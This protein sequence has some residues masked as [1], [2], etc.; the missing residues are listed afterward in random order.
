MVG[1]QKDPS[2]GAVVTRWLRWLVG[3]VVVIGA[4]WRADL[5]WTVSPLA[6]E[7]TDWRSRRVYNST[8]SAVDVLNES[9]WLT[10]RLPSGQTL[11]RVVTNA[12]VPSTFLPVSPSTEKWQYTLHYQLLSGAGA[13][14]LDRQYVHRTGLTTYV[15]PQ[16]GEKFTSRF[17]LDGDLFPT[18]GKV[19][20]INAGGLSAEPTHLRLRVATKANP[21][22]SLTARVFCRESATVRKLSTVWQ[23]LSEKQQLIL[24]RGNLY[25]PELLSKE[26]KH[27]LLR[28]RWSAIAPEGIAGKDYVRRDLYALKEFEEEE[29]REPVLPAGLLVTPGLHGIVTIPEGGGVLRLLF[30]PISGE[31]GQTPDHT[32]SLRW[33]GRG[34]VQRR[35]FTCPWSDNGSECR[36]LL[37]GGLL[38]VVT[39]QALVVRAFL[40]V[41][42]QETEITPEP[43]LTPMYLSQN[44]TPVEFAIMHV[45]QEPTPFRLTLRRPLAAI[46]GSTDSVNST[47]STLAPG[48]LYELLDARQQVLHAGQ[49]SIDTPASVY[50]RLL[51]TLEG[52]SLTDPVHYYF[53]LPPSVTR[54]RVRALQG[55]ILIT[56]ANRPAT[57]VREIQVPEDF[58]LFADSSLQR[59]WFPLQPVGIDQ[60]RVENRVLMVAVQPR[61]PQDNSE[62]MAGR[63]DWE[64]YQPPHGWR[65]RRLLLPMGPSAVRREQTLLVTFSEIPL[66]REHTVQFVANDGRR[67]IT[68][69]M[70]YIR[71]G[72]GL[73]PVLVR[74][75]IDGRVQ[76]EAFIQGLAGEISL[77][78][79][80]AGRHRIQVDAP[81]GGRV[82]LNHLA[83]DGGTAMALVKMAL[84]FDADGLGFDYEKRTRDEEEGLSVRLYTPYG[85]IQPTRVRVRIDGPPTK[86]IG[87]YTSWTF[88]ERRYRVRP[89]TGIRVPVLDTRDEAVTEGQLFS[90]PLGSDLPP[91]RYRIQLE[92]EDGPGGYLILSK[93]TP[94]VSEQRTVFL[95]RGVT[96]DVAPE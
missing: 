93:I 10:Y 87:P 29:T 80:S 64:D 53:S 79:L 23:R 8:V 26:E 50:D 71:H 51:T 19:M 18:D 58:Y 66:A 69:T 73:G 76:R 14:L 6:R 3:I 60:L 12:G 83:L 75:F 77:P 46:E 16:T 17:Y 96:I 2:G 1:V 72:R 9:Q 74:T 61:P 11:I 90:V 59:S 55:P 42:G 21:I 78:P 44:H 67:E 20:V 92:L 33:Y 28:Q 89:V 13:V 7:T 5:R 39:P 88:R 35:S 31:Q 82:L 65:A 49:M 95:E 86:A 36:E 27:N 94:G 22:V 84:R 52:N 38:E 48:L 85:I 62:V 70:V 91:G 45:G 57:L 34:L 47:P 25:P 15:D 68:P 40:A 41:Q 30:E 54:V 81:A 63:Y 4:V 43:S 37:L 24:A 32:I 56:G